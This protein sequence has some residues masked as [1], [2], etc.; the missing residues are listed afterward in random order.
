MSIKISMSVMLASSLVLSYIVKAHAAEP[1]KQDM[2][3]PSINVSKTEQIS[4][5][6]V[7]ASKTLR[8]IANARTFIAQNQP[9]KALSALNH[10]NDYLQLAPTVSPESQIKNQVWIAKKHLEREPGKNAKTDLVPALMA[11]NETQMT[12]ALSQAKDAISNACDALDKG[13]NTLALRHLNKADQLLVVKTFDNPLAQ[14]SQSV[15][16]AQQY[17]QQK[18][19]KEADAVL[20]KAENSL[21]YIP[22][23]EEPPATTASRNVKDAIKE[24]AEANYKAAQVSLSNAQQWLRRSAQTSDLKLREASQGISQDLESLKQNLKTSASGVQDKFNVINP[25]LEI[26]AEYEREHWALM[27]RKLP[28]EEKQSREKLLQARYQ[29]ALAQITTTGT[30]TE[31]LLN[32]TI[33]ALQTAVLKAPALDKPQIE[34]IEKQVTL[35]KQG[36]QSKEPLEESYG[37]VLE[38]LDRVIER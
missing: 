35:I 3:P 27:L 17:L 7:I 2:Q 18:N 9:D 4:V 8:E 29:L 33:E 26:L 6:S 36:L 37:Q 31:E 13:N 10:A 23:I 30:K 28:D 21:A 34:A 16:S 22:L 32:N 20:M 12:P 5:I 24:A 25:R 11:F 14:T 1:L 19:L 15:Q 38:K